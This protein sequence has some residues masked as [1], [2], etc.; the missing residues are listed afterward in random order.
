[1][2]NPEWEQDDLARRQIMLEMVFKT[3][4][5]IAQVATPILLLLIL[6]K[7]G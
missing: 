7:M 6:R 5:W 2:N 1:M 3:I 4:Q